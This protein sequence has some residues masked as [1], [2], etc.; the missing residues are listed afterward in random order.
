M[1]LGDKELKSKKKWRKK[2]SLLVPSSEHI[3]VAR[4]RLHPDDEKILIRRESEETLAK[5][6]T[7]TRQNTGN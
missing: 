2:S 4:Q 5:E 7:E 3:T 1:D 6:D